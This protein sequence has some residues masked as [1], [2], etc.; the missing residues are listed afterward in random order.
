M[1][2]EFVREDISEQVQRLNED[3]LALS[4]DPQDEELRRSVS[5]GFHNL[6]A[7]GRMLGV[8]R[9]VNLVHEMEGR[10][11]GIWERGGAMDSGH[12]EAFLR[13]LDVVGSLLKAAAGQKLPP[14]EED[15]GELAQFLPDFLES[16][17]EHLGGINTGLGRLREEPGNE[18]ALQEVFRRAHSL[19][20]SAMT[21]GL[22]EISS[23]A[24]GIEEV[25]RDLSEGRGELSE[26]V[27]DG[28]LE[29]L[30]AINRSL[31][32][33]SW[34]RRKEAPPRPPSVPQEA[35]GETVRVRTELLDA[36]LNLLEELFTHHLGLS[37]LQADAEETLADLRTEAPQLAA[38]M[39][40]FCRQ[41]GDRLEGV[42]LL[43]SELRDTIMRAR[44]LPV[45]T[46]FHMLPRAVR[47]LAKQFGKEAK[48]VQEGGEVEVDKSILEQ[49]WDPLIHLI[50]NALDHGIEPKEERRKSGKPEAGTVR[51]TARQQEGRVLIEVE[52]DGRGMDPEEL[53]DTAVR[54]GLLSHREADA[55]SSEEACELIFL[56][57][58][59]TSTSVTDVSGRGIG[60]D[61]VRTNVERLKGRVSVSTRK[62]RGTKFVLD[63]PLTLI[64]APAFL[65]KTGGRTLALP[66]D[67][68]E[69]AVRLRKDDAYRQ[70]GGRTIYIGGHLIPLIS[71]MEA[72][73]WNG[74]DDPTQALVVRTEGRWVALGVEE[75]LGEQ[76]VVVKSPGSF[77]LRRTPF[78]SGVTVLGSGEVVP[79]LE[80]SALVRLA[81]RRGAQGEPEP[82][83]RRPRVLL[84][85]D[86]LVTQQVEKSLLEGA[87]FEVEVAS[88][89]EEA[90]GKLAEKP[91]DLV[92]TDI[93]MPR[94]DGFTLI[95][96]IRG[97][98]RYMDVPVVIVTSMVREEDRRRG[99]EAGADAYILK[100]GFRGENLIDTVRLL[101]GRRRR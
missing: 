14:T 26:E 55:L 68:V 24:H 1:S 54:R 44:M 81:G 101:I 74:G 65:L 70:D 72:L 46:V 3:L 61:V 50:R 94:M 71:L 31:D 66:A 10:L 40:D 43:L 88:D 80:P 77:L 5:Q 22:T 75:V 73:G 20:G 78:L 12:L 69:Q 35:L 16:A 87:G 92:V 9:A 48:L 32:A 27:L 84:V 95:Q 91:F 90:L 98:E 8:G 47:D 52:D 11:K 63:F 97:D 79:I 36:L 96:R 18:E 39:D 15:L 37:E 60:L 28:V 83:H 41:F 45:S 62:G 58:F 67:A 51:V 21:M 99:L 33:L 30:D 25:F 89:G 76:E 19:K 29:A 93:Q 17:R 85:E 6:K 49:I 82:G 13:D 53:K 59:S 64:T 2:H 38:R 34:G 7:L 100:S 23:L 86:Q 4:L 42:H 56:P 57:G